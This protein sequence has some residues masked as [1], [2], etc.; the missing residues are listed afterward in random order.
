MWPVPISDVALIS[1]TIVIALLYRNGPSWG[2]ER[3]NELAWMMR[4]LLD[5]ILAT[6]PMPEDQDSFQRCYRGNLRVEDDM[7]G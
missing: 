3:L 4:R 7:S 1:I 6:H 5:C 2:V